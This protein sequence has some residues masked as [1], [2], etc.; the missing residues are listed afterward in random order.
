MFGVEAEVGKSKKNWGERGTMTEYRDT[1]EI[2]HPT[3]P[4]CNRVSIVFSICAAVS[5][6]SAI[7]GDCIEQ[8]GL[9]IVGH[10]APWL[11]F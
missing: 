8:S 2:P 6:R 11:Y 9:C 1:R 4:S 5:G 10:Q 3:H 7:F